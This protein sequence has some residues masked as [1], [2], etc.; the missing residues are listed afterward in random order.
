MSYIKMYDSFT[1]GFDKRS[2]ASLRILMIL[3]CHLGK[4]NMI[5]NE[6]GI[7]ATIGEIAKMVNRSYDTTR[8]AI[9]ELIK[10]N[11]LKCKHYR[12]FHTFQMNPE[13]AEV[14]H[15]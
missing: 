5:V 8:K 3:M 9:A 7:D 14:D 15:E 4:D 13:I 12:S 2:K 1:D 10:L 6:D 11:K